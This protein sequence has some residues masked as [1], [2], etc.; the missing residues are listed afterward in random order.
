MDDLK[1]LMK[2]DNSHPTIISEKIN[3]VNEITCSL[4][5][6]PAPTLIKKPNILSPYSTETSPEPLLNPTIFS[7]LS[8]RPPVTFHINIFRPKLRVTCR[9]SHARYTPHTLN[10]SRFKCKLLLPSSRNVPHATSSLF[11]PHTFHS[12]HNTPDLNY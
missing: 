11:N 4:K 7:H 12:N 3:C 10:P 5:R 9:L 8:L 2:F 1:G 6:W